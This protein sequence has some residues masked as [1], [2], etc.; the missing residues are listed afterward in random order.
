MP[1]R[2]RLLDW[3]P[4][5]KNT[6]LGFAKVQFSSGLIIGEIAV[7]R[8]GNRMWAAPPSRPWIENGAVVIGERGRPRYQSIIGFA[9]HGVQASWSRQVLNA[10]SEEHPALFPDAVEDDLN[11]G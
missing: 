11:F 5:H 7:H 3:R 4:L 10:L 9:N 6:L 2:P 8:S 1:H